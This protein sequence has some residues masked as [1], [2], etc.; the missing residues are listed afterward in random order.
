VET[1][2]SLGVVISAYGWF[3]GCDAENGRWAGWLERLFAV[4]AA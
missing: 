3:L 2:L 4:A 1:I